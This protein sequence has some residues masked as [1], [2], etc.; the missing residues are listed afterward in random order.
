[1]KLYTTDCALLAPPMGANTQRFDIPPYEEMALYYPQSNQKR[2]LIL[3]GPPS[4][5]RHELRQSLLE[6]TTRFAAA[7]PRSVAGSVVEDKVVGVDVVDVDAAVGVK[8]MLLLPVAQICA[9]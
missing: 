2:P 1:M 6:D 4:I 3:V 9:S 7:V 8:L 5:G